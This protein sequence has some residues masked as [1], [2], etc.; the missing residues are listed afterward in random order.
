MGK[1]GQPSVWDIRQLAT[2]H[3]ILPLGKA[4]FLVIVVSISDLHT[5]I[6]KL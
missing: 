1:E 3:G 2:V 4:A 5:M 6:Y